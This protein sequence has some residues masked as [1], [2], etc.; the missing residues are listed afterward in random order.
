MEVEIGDLRSTVRAV[1]GDALLSPST[2]ERIVRIVL[3]AVDDRDSH[4]R[5]VRDEERIS[6]GI[7]HDLD[8]TEWWSWNR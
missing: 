1:D 8:E 5:R 4:R 2:L 7:N 3:Q 6:T